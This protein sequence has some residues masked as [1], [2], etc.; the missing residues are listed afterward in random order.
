MTT[1]A[2]IA[3]TVMIDGQ[4][5]ARDVIVISDD[6][7]G[8]KVVGEG[9]S[10]AAGDFDITYNDWE[11]SVIAL[12][13]D[14]YG[15]EFATETALNQGEIVHPGTPNGYVYEVTTAG[16]TGTEEPAWSTSA[17]V[18]SGSVTFNPRPYYRAVASGP[19]QGDIISIGTPTYPTVVLDSSP[20]AYYRLEETT[21][22]VIVGESGAPGTIVG[23]VALGQP[24]LIG[25]GSS[26]QLVA[27]SYL[28]APNPVTAADSTFSIELLVSGL[29][30]ADAQACLACDKRGPGFGWIVGYSPEVVGTGQVR[31]Y[32]GGASADL[33]CPIADGEAHHV[34]FVFDKNHATENIRVYVDGGKTASISRGLSLSQGSEI[35]FGSWNNTLTGTYD[36]IA[37]YDRVLTDAEILDH[38]EASGLGGE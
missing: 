14:Q 33:Y 8:R 38:Y 32:T 28:K 13:L 3:G 29:T 22:A 18:T 25:E 5:A 9:S 2:R 36:E 34:V 6:P 19:L 10:D 4:P 15:D 23:S 1:Q 37:V 11:G 16:T 26:M 17:A 12:A 21:G 20:V 24:G 35:F 7:T 30:G 27:S 31:V